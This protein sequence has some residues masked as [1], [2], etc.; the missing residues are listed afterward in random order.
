MYVWIILIL[1][2][3]RHAS[4]I[5]DFC[6]SSVVENS[7]P[8]PLKYGFSVFSSL[9]SEASIRCVFDLVIL[10]FISLISHIFHFLIYLCNILDNFL[11]YIFQLIYSVF[12]CNQVYYS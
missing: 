11:R 2:D 6:L 8:L 12:S 3:L 10:S 4:L 1:L 7:Q 9:P 5:M